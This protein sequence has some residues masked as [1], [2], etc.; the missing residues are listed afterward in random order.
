MAH[1]TQSSEPALLKLSDG[2]HQG[3]PFSTSNQAQTNIFVKY[4]NN[5]LS[6]NK[7]KKTHKIQAQILFLD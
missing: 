1:R 6:E 5:E 7:I 2:N 4:N 3:F